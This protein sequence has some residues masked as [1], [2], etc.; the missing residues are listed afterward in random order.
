[1][2]GPCHSCLPC[3]VPPALEPGRGHQFYAQFV[4][5][6]DV[7]HGDQASDSQDV[8]RLQRQDDRHHVHVFR[9]QS[10]QP[11]LPVA[12]QRSGQEG[13]QSDPDNRAVRREREPEASD[14]TL[15]LN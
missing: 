14:L 9:A 7:F 15:T 6:G 12:R 2:K 11:S 3:V 10:R 8:G 1:M 13:T 4:F 5:A